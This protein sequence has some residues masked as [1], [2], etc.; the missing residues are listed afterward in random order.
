MADAGGRLSEACGWYRI[1]ENELHDLSR[2]ATNER[3]KRLEG[4]DDLQ[5]VLLLFLQLG[6]FGFGFLEV[7][8]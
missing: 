3:S 5:D 4:L 1:H 7:L 8:F 6:D 2:E